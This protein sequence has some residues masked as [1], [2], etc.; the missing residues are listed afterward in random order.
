V[1]RLS[2]RAKNLTRRWTRFWMRYA[3]LTPFGRIATGL[4][5]WWAPPH[6]ARVGLAKMNEKGFISPRAVIRHKDLRLGKNVFMDDRVVIYQRNNGDFTEIGD[7][8][9]IY[10]DT[11][12][13]TG[14][15]GHFKIGHDSSIHPRCQLNAYVGSIEIGN[16]V[17]IA[18]NCALYPY[19]HGLKPNEII[20]NQPLESK[21]PI[22]VGDGAW[23][24]VGAI[25]TSGVTIGEGAAVGAGS[26]VTEDVPPNAIAAGNPAKVIRRR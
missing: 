26:L 25:I 1:G 16:H 12:I 2:T 5:C 10:R 23:L 15:G 6:K 21:G 18:P 11:I 14:F 17:M 13:E 4:A 24:G 20:L 22:V 19:N 7:R 3:D 8:V 9:C